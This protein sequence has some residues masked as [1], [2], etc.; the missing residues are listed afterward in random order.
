MNPFERRSHEPRGL[1]DLLRP[2]PRPWFRR[3]AA[4]AGGPAFGAAAAPE[5]ALL[6]RLTALYG[7][8]LSL[9][10][11]ALAETH[12]GEDALSVGDAVKAAQHFAFGDHY[13]SRAGDLE[14]AIERKVAG[15]GRSADEAAALATEALRRARERRYGSA[16]L[17]AR[18]PFA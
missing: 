4:H 3:T 18:P 7:R 12:V 14:R 11:R 8:L 6:E 9:R 17:D 16:E 2:G 1:R 10:D 15:L 5:A 13:R